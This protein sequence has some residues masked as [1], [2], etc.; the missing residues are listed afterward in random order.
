MPD[1]IIRAISFRPRIV[2]A[3]LGNSSIPLEAFSWEE[4]PRSFGAGTTVAVPQVSLEVLE[5]GLLAPYLPR[6]LH[7]KDG[8]AIRPVC[9]FLELHA[10]VTIGDN[11]G[12]LERPIT[13]D[14][15]E[16]N[17]FDLTCISFRIRA[18]NRKAARRTGDPACVNR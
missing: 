10:Q 3:R 14:L 11:T 4:D 13:T 1:A 15:L 17:G 7:F 5:D 6:D 2:V 8:D 9:R 18:V 16:T 12:P